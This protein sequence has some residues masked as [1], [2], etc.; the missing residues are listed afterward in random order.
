MAAYIKNII[1]G[2]NDII[3]PKTKSGAV[4]MENSRTLDEEITNRL[5]ISGST[6]SGQIIG[7]VWYKEI[8]D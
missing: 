8:T 5:I 6:P 4:V 7:D 3:Y 2:N 1:D